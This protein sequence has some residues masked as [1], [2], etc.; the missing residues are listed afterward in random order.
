[1]MT[2][3]AV[4][5][6][7]GAGLLCALASLFAFSKAWTRQVPLDKKGGLVLLAVGLAAAASAHVANRMLLRIV[8]AVAIL[9]AVY[10]LI[11]FGK[12]AAFE[13]GSAAAVLLLGLASVLIASSLV[14]EPNH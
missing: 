11:T 1:M 12:S 7:R 9:V 3:A 4:R 2:A 8:A 10:A 6:A 14:T 13:G 5:L